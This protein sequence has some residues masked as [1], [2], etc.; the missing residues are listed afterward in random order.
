MQT[1]ENRQRDIEDRYIASGFTFYNSIMGVTMEHYGCSKVINKVPPGGSNPERG[2]FPDSRPSPFAGWERWGEPLIK[3]FVQQGVDH[4]LRLEKALTNLA[5]E[6]RS[7]CFTIIP[8]R[9][10]L[11]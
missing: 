8:L 6:K 5:T 7:C 10:T 1:R 2:R 11:R 4:S 9:C 3:A